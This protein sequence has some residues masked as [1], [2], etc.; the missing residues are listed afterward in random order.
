MADSD[1]IVAL[2][3]GFKDVHSRLDKMTDLYSSHATKIALIEQKLPTQPC[4]HFE[5][6]V[7]NHPDKRD[8]QDLIDNA[9]DVKRGAKEIVIDLF[10]GTIKLGAAV[11]AGAFGYKM[12]RQH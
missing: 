9:N 8:L 12:F 7:E 5:R 11:V 6:H 3:V 2:N 4:D 1:I 10:K